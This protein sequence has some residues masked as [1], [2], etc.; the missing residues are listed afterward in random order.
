MAAA[1]TLTVGVFR[2]EHVESR[3][4]ID[5]ACSD[6]VTD[7][8]TAVFLR[9]AAKPFQAAAVVRCGALKRLGDDAE[10]LAIVAG[11]HSGEPVHTAL[12]A[13]LLA[14]LGLDESALCCGVHPPFHAETAER[15]GRAISPL[16]HNCSGKHAGM[17]AV[18]LE[19]GVSPESY[20]D[21][22]GAVQEVMRRTVAEA[23]GIPLEQVVTAIDGCGAATFAVPLVAAARGFARLVRP[24]EASGDLRHAL[25]R[26]AEAMRRHPHLIGGSGRFDT[27]L[28][29]AAHGRLLAKGGAE[30]VEGVA[31]FESGRGLC[32]KVRDGA[33]R[34]VGPATL[35]LLRHSG[36]IDDAA[37]GSLEVEHR[38]I[39]RNYAGAAVGRIEATVG[40]NC[41]RSRRRDQRQEERRRHGAP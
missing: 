19:L 36:W 8:A 12:V 31:D 3:H 35:E 14:R 21:A 11:S 9:S 1:G 26:V 17:L 30:G 22:D 4:E 29:E 38:P 2:G 32:L 23:C 18:A 25:R 6:S 37:L 27:R 28:M 24:D 7:D 33:S 10:A 13:G 34:A 40:E 15:L 5:F 20:L 41:G 16:H 39:L